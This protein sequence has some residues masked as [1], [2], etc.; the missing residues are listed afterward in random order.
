[1]ENVGEIFNKFMRNI[2]RWKNFKIN[3]EKFWDLK[4]KIVANNEVLKNFE[5]LSEKYLNFAKVM[6]KR[7]RNSDKIRLIFQNLKHFDDD[8]IK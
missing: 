8:F 2:G 5:E 7:E 1:M 3:V 4:M 6:N